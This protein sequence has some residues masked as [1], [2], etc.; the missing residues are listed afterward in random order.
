MVTTAISNAMTKI[1]GSRND[2]LVK[3]YRRRVQLINSLEPDVRNEASHEIRKQLLSAARARAELQWAPAFTL[4]G[5]L[6]ETVGWY[7]ELL[8]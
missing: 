2:R 4:E 1:F 5:G 8:A 3:M 6:R 7:Q